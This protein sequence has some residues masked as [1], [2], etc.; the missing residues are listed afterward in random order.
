MSLLR[1][2]RLVLVGVAIALARADGA[3][4]ADSYFNACGV[5]TAYTRASATAPGSVTVG[6]RTLTIAAGAMEGGAIGP[7]I[8]T[9]AGCIG[10]TQAPN[11]VL[12]QVGKMAMPIGI[13]GTVAEFHPANATANGSVTLGD[14]RAIYPIA[15]GTT[16]SG[17]NA[18]GYRCFSLTLDAAGDAVI[19]GTMLVPPVSVSA[20]E[21]SARS[22]VESAPSAISRAASLPSTTT[23][24]GGLAVLGL[25]LVLTGIVMLRLPSRPLEHKDL[26]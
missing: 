1:F 21:H 6:S 22:S 18:S 11:G 19:N 16:I 13:C 25:V 2:S 3:N 10:G 7:P 26:G 8:T 24:G 12:T 4:A 14:T 20:P 15:R 5:I 9:G 17:E 23:S